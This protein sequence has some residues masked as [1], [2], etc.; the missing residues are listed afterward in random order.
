MSRWIR[1]SLWKSTKAPVS[2]GSGVTT[3]GGPGLS[4]NIASRTA[5]NPAS[6]PECTAPS[7]APSAVPTPRLAKATRCGD[8]IGYTVTSG[9][10]ATTDQT[11][12][13]TTS[14]MAR[15]S[16]PLADAL[17]YNTTAAATAISDSAT[18]SGASQTERV[19]G[20]LNIARAEFAMAQP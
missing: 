7:P 12:P 10:L 8:Q 9:A 20:R 18:A 2:G 13:A 16:R 14:G 3:R 5:I 11:R 6:R 17:L 4:A 15:A 19:A 1:A